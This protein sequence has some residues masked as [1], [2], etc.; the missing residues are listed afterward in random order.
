MKKL[1]EIFRDNRELFDSGEPSANHFNKFLE[2]LD[3]QQTGLKRERWI[4]RLVHVA[5]VAA[6]ILLVV[7]VVML[8][9]TPPVNKQVAGTVS[10]EVQEINTY[11][12]NLVNLNIQ[13]LNEVLAKCPSQKKDFQS[14]FREL[15]KS[16][17]SILND[18]EE[19]PRDERV[20]SALVYHYQ[21]KLEIIESTMNY[22]NEKCI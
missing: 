5:A 11:Y 13:E 7:S 4:R 16:I 18:L 1:E 10:Q 21:L 20:I 6:V 17:E 22:A 3:A 19:N 9:K 15:E 12:R 14:C 8:H 2:K